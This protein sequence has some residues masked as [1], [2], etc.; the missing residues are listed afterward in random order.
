MT[1]SG[2]LRHGYTDRWQTDTSARLGQRGLFPEGRGGRPQLN[3]KIHLRS[4]GGSRRHLSVKRNLP[5]RPEAIELQRQLQTQVAPG[6]VISAF[7]FG[8]AAAIMGAHPCEL[9]SPILVNAR[10]CLL[11]SVVDLSPRLSPPAPRVL[12]RG[13]RAESSPATLLPG[14]DFLGPLRR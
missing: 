5:P 9:D 1:T 7:S 12:K 8:D 14:S 4:A 13:C 11:G 6:F 2:L 3:F 10:D